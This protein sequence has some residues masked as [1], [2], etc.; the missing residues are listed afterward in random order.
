MHTLAR[1]LTRL[2]FAAG[3][4]P[5]LVGCGGDDPIESGG[6][7]TITFTTW[8]EEYVEDAIPADPD[9][10]F[11]D[12]WTVRY[13]RFLVNLGNIRVAT[14]SGEIAATMPGSYLVDNTIEGVKEVV[15]F[16]VPA[17]AYEAVG[18]DI[19]PVTADAE[20][21]PGAFETDRTMMADNGYSVYLAGT[22]TKGDVTK[23]FAWGFTVGTRYEQCHSVLDGRDT[24]GLVVTNGGTVEAELTTH[25]DHPFYD[26]LRASSTVATSLR[27]DAL[28]DTDADDDGEITL[29]ELDAELIDV[30]RYNPSGLDA[31][32]YRELVTELIRTVGH[33]RGEG[34]CSVRRL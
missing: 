1:K 21:G 23:R 14:A 29:E 30:L 4:A 16:D 8:G 11:V 2:L 33:F 31:S 18:Y 7:G 34:E 10:G 12:G 25:G 6:R 24:L 9:G 5:M 20:L 13:S 26:R 28:A 27:F 19:A 3:A 32:T 15:S 17:R 22:A